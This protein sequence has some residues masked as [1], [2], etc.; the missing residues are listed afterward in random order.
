MRVDDQWIDISDY[1]GPWDETI[2]DK[3]LMDG[4]VNWGERL[5]IGLP[6]EW[7]VRLEDLIEH[8][9]YVDQ[10]AAEA[11][12]EASWPDAA[13]LPAPQVREILRDKLLLGSDNLRL[14]RLDQRNCPPCLPSA[15]NTT[16]VH[17][18]MS[19]MDAVR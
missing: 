15:V 10:N 1:D 11:L 16:A 19:N 9:N 5:L 2:S 3:A 8:Q 4:Y 6:K 18:D 13:H 17:N 12:E 7:A 14:G